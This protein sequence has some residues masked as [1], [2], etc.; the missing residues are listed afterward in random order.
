MPAVKTHQRRCSPI[1][2]DLGAAGV[3]VVQL[4]RQGEAYVVSA[5]VQSE[6]RSAGIEGEESNEV[7]VRRVAECLS[8]TRFS[9]RSAAVTLSSPDLEFHALDLP[10]AVFKARASNCAQVVHSEVVRLMSDASGGVETRHWLLP[11]SGAGGS[12]PSAIGV[13]IG[14]DVVLKAIATCDDAGVN[15]LRADASA[16]GLC[17]F[18]AV[19]QAWP[20]E[21]T[22]G[23]LDIGERQT[24]LVL[25]VDGTPVL[26]RPAGPGSG[27]WTRRIAETLEL[28]AKAAEVHKR[29]HGIA[30][31]GRHAER[32]D[33]DAVRTELPAILAG[34]LRGDLND[35]AAEIKRSYEYVLRCYPK[36]EAG[37][38]VLVGGGSL[39]GNLPEFLGNALG[40][41]V[42]RASMYL[43]EPTCRLDY[44]SGHNDRL[45]NFA[46]AIGLVLGE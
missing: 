13:G 2:I 29:E 21:C 25:C 31:T 24:R 26:V 14:H 23:V 42:R 6:R 44:R 1:G 10:E 3:R 36:R 4:M 8:K 16:T 46:V 18:G 34:A 45:E 22:Y 41:P 11:P 32:S 28:S 43:D 38:L 5:S 19:L 33:T 17:R 9:G 20:S 12:P 39:L 7:T 35:L 30:L 27:A 37:D 15:C 40:I